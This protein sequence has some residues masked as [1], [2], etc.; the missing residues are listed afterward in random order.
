MIIVSYPVYIDANHRKYSVIK[1]LVERGEIEKART[2]AKDEADKLFEVSS[3][4]S[5]ITDGGEFEGLT[6]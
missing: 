4:G 3:I 5:I 2:M 1:A 6:E